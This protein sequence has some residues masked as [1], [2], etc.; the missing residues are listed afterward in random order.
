MKTSD[1]I[2]P[3]LDWVVLKSIGHQPVVMDF[4][5]FI[6][7]K[8][9]MRPSWGSRSY[10]PSTN[11]SQGGPIIERER[12]A[13]DWIGSEWTAKSWELLEGK[14]LRQRSYAYGPTPLITA[15]RCF[16][17]SKLGDEVDIPKE[18]L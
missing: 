17:A 11:W 14:V 8:K 16:V 4:G 9:V 1:L 5:T 10:K 7:W 13:L 6:P 12:I 3:S 2:G 18:L 15:M